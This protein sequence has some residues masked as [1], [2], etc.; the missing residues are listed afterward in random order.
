MNMD[1]ASRPN[2]IATYGLP[3]VVLYSLG[4]LAL[5]GLGG[6]VIFTGEPILAYLERKPFMVL[7]VLVI[8]IGGALEIARCAIIFYNIA[9][10]GGRAL[11]VENGRIVFISKYISSMPIAQITR[12]LPRKKK[13]VYVIL[14]NGKLK[15]IY[16]AFLK[17]SDPNIIAQKI[18][19][20]VQDGRSTSHPASP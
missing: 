3:F 18:E 17:P 13:A 20:L 9:V 11:F 7:Y 19:A 1:R 10:N 12:V 5:L 16:T 8:A 14:S 6:F 4:I 15:K 2:V